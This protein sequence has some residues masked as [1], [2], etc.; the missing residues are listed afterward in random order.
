MVVARRF[1]ELGREIVELHVV[2][3]DQRADVAEGQ[4]VVLGLQPENVEHRLR[5]EDAAARQVPVPQAAA[6]AV[7]RGIDA[8]ADRLVDQVGFARARRLPVE[9]EAED[10]HDEAGGGRERDG[11]RGE[12]APGRQRGV[13]RLHDGDLPERRLQHAHGRQRAGV[14]RQ[15]DFHDAGAGAEGGERLR[16]PEEVDQAAADGGVGGGRGG[17]HHA[18]RIGQQEAPPGAGGP[19]RQRAREHLLRPRQ[20]VGGVA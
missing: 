9:G 10:Q 6:A 4:Q 15:G 16:R 2:R 1:G 13:A 19:R 14:V 12:R 5:P 8:A 7:E 20:R 11:Q 17:G 18:V 3:M